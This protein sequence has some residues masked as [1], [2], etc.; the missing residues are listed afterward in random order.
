VTTSSD[1]GSASA[2]SERSGESDSDRMAEK[3]EESGSEATE[4]DAQQAEAAL[5]GYLEAQANGEW[6]RACSYLAEDLR[7]LYARAAS[8]AQ[9]G[10]CPGFTRRITQR[11]SQ[12]KRSS[13]ADIDIQ[14]VRIDGA[15]GRI[16]YLDSS[17]KS[18]KKPVRQEA[19]EWK[20]SSLL[21]QLLEQA[22]SSR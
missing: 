9:G 20:L 22:R 1:E 11:L 3:D 19:G 12:S 18:V 13:L 2:P 21:V 7:K 6:S 14:S 15:S 10:G 5:V 8:S 17:G 4:S 16:V